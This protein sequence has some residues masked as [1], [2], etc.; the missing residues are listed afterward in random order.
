[1]RAA[2]IALTLAGLFATLPIRAEIDIAVDGVDDE[3]AANVRNFLSLSSYARVAVVDD[4]RIRQLFSQAEAE[5]AKSLQAFGYYNPTIKSH[6][7]S[8]GDDWKVTLDIDKGPPVILE[9]VAVEVVGPGLDHPEFR[10]VVEHPLLRPGDRLIHA[11]FD[12]T[13]ARLTEIAYEYGFFEARF[14]RHRLEVDPVQ[15]VANAFITFAS[16]PRYYF[17]ELV[18]DQDVINDALLRRYLRFREG[19]AY[20]SKLLLSSK[21]VLYDTQFF[22]SVDLVPETD[23]ASDGKVPIRIGAVA[24]KKHSF[25]IGLGYATDTRERISGGWVNRR[26]NRYGHSLSATV[27]Y[28]NIKTVGR[29]SYAM[30]I[31]DPALERLTHSF[32]TI[33]EEPGDITSNRYE[34]GTTLAQVFGPWQRAIDLF[35]INEESDFGESTQRDSFFVPGIGFSRTHSDDKLRPTRGFRIQSRLSGSHTALGASANFARIETRARILIPLGARN[36]LLL[37]GEGGAILTDG[38]SNLAASQRFF[39]GG[40]NSI[41]GYSYKSLSPRDTDGQRVGGRYLATGTVEFTRRLFDNW[42]AAIFLD[43]GNAFDSFN[44][45]FERSWGL[46]IRYFSPVGKIRVDIAESLTDSSKSKQ[47]YISIGPDL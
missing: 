13:K 17:G 24:G 9:E 10:R 19:E 33:E 43:G 39:A 18:I 32:A 23:D 3:I 20:D 21:Y 11:N 2:S 26:V 46:G 44:D 38:F 1:M 8:D 35:Y 42:G 25:A 40:D 15:N 36:S 12:D 28:S 37:R 31:G 27:R 6:L 29:A 4:T 5:A 16:G 22:S 47:L 7:A 34:I 45:D 14:T 41:R 30:P